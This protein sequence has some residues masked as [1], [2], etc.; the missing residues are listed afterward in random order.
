MWHFFCHTNI[1]VK[2]T[3]YTS[4]TTVN[5]TESVEHLS[6]CSTC[7]RFSV[8]F[9][10]HKNCEKSPLGT[11]KCHGTKTK[12]YYGFNDDKYLSVKVENIFVNTEMP[13]HMLDGYVGFIHAN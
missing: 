10:I 1:F 12:W 5:Y 4:A 13:T 6:L 2:P 3:L 8:I 11:G 9:Y 7:L